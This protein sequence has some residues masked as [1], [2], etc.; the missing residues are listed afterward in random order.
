M[1]YKNNNV[2]EFYK[3]LP[4]NISGDLNL[5]IKQIKM[6]NPLD[7]YPVL[8]NLIPE[9]KKIKIIDIGC[10][11]GWL[12]NS[13][14]YHLRD[15][16]DVIG[17]DFNPNVIDYAKKVKSS[18]NVKSKFFVS[19]LFTFEEENKF[20]IIISLG[21]LHHT[22]HCIEAINHVMKYAKKN[23]MYLLVSIISMVGDLS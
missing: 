20:D 18:L 10:G 11:G 12:V 15:N 7:I 17:V 8:K 3:E 6:N 21:V 19:D 22:N 2:L 9:N 1:T 5:A 13:L 4:F 14:A 16:I 23:H